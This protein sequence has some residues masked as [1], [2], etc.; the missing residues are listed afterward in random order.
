MH[1]ILIDWLAF[2]AVAVLCHARCHGVLCEICSVVPRLYCIIGVLCQCHVALD[3]L[4]SPLLTLR[5]ASAW[6]SALVDLNLCC[7]VKHSA[8]MMCYVVLCCAVLLQASLPLTP[9]QGSAWP[10]VF[11][12]QGHLCLA[13]THSA[14]MLYRSVLCC[15]VLLQASSLL[16]PKQASA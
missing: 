7:A 12:S 15:A 1:H 2:D 14:D 6:L 9:R 3:V 16:T 10:L 4:P 8:N 11:V 5:Q 13:V